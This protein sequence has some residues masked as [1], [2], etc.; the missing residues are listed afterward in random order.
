MKRLSANSVCGERGQARQEDI[1]TPLET[2]CERNIR[3]QS[4]SFSNAR[5]Q[6]N[7]SFTCSL[8]LGNV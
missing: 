3:V 8:I 4:G 6:T 1:A 2:C 7:T 5:L